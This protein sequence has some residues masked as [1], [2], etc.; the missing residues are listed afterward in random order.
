MDEGSDKVMLSAAGMGVVG[1]DRAGASD[2][3]VDIF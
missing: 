3:T 2:L 1:A